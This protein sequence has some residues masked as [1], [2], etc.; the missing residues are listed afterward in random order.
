MVTTCDRCGPSVRA[1]ISYRR[2][3]SVWS[4]CDHHAREYHP[5]LTKAGYTRQTLEAMIAS[6]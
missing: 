1:T 4:W 2:G 3:S 6:G 5:A